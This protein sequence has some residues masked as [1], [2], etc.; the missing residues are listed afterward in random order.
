MKSSG[1]QCSTQHKECTDFW[2]FSI[3][4]LWWTDLKMVPNGPQ[5]LA[6]MSLCNLLAL[7]VGRV[8]D[9]LLIQKTAKVKRW[10]SH[11]MHV[12]LSH[13]AASLKKPTAVFWTVYEGPSCWELWVGWRDWEPQSYNK[14]LNPAN[15]QWIRHGHFPRWEHSLDHT[16]VVVQWDSE[17]EDPSKL[18]RDRLPP[19]AGG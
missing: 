18:C 8:C 2:T 10:H 6:F 12:R 13:S 1:Q 9:L 3:M 15:N 7:R 16:L 4:V 14:W 19:E 17:A 5:F 11:V